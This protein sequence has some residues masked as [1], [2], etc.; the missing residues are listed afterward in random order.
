MF[1]LVLFSYIYIE[2][3]YYTSY[4]A[5]WFSLRWNH[6]QAADTKNIKFNNCNNKIYKNIIEISKLLHQF[7]FYN[8]EIAISRINECYL[9]LKKLDKKKH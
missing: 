9:D 5:I 2:L 4:S 3:Y 1:V 8:V 6:N 7:I